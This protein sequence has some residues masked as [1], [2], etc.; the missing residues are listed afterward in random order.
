MKIAMIIPYKN[1]ERFLDRCLKSIGSQPFEVFLVDD[2]SEDDS[3][4]IATEGAM[5]SEGWHTFTLDEC[6]HGVSSARNM[7]L[8][9]AYTEKCDYITFLDADDKL[10]PNAY[11]AIVEAIKTWPDSSI[12]QLNHARW[13]NGVEYVRHFNKRGLYSLTNLPV[14]WPPVWNKVYKAESIKAL[15]FKRNLS[16]GEDEIFNLEIMANTRQIAC[17]EQIACIHHYDNPESLMKTT[18]KEDLLSEQDHLLTFLEHHL[19]DA[20]LCEL[21]RNRQAELWDNPTYRKCFGGSS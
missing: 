14:F 5:S 9:A 4:L 7:G 16:H 2:H 17:F 18:T 11:N 19:N 15:M 1:A 21:V 8:Y 6:Q 12:I 20:E 10:R 3:G 13:K